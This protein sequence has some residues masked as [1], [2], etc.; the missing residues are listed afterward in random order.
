M[1]AQEQAA[2]AI[3]LATAL[4]VAM[5]WLPTP[6]NRNIV[7]MA[8]KTRIPSTAIHGSV[9][10]LFVSANLALWTWVV[11]AAALWYGLV[12]VQ[13]I[14]NWWVA[15]LFGIHQGEITPEEYRGHYAGNLRFLPRIGDHPVI[16]DVQHTLIHLALLGAVIL[17]WR[18][19]A[20][21]V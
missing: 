18:S 16:P 20:D 19:F 9:G 12:L 21:L 14:R 3:A 8:A 15:Y 11:L 2:A 6:L 13:G 7:G 1:D 17:C 10:V 4:I 5:D